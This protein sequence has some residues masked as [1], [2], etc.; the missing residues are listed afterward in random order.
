MTSL[1]SDKGIGNQLGRYDTPYTTADYMVKLALKYL[2]NPKKI[3]DPAMGGGVFIDAL[4]NNGIP[5]EK[6]TAFDIDSKVFEENP[7]KSPN[8]QV[9]DALLT[10]YGKYDLIIGNPPYK[11]RRQSEYIKKNKKTLSKLYEPIGLYNLYALF[12][13]KAINQLNENGIL[14]FIV[15]DSFCMNRYYRKLRNFILSSVKIKELILAPSSLFKTGK[16]DVRTVIIIFQKCSGPQNYSERFNSEM[17]LVDRLISEMQY[18]LPPKEQFIPQRK[19]HEMPD[20]KFFVGMPE[21]IFNLISKCKT[22]FGDISEGGTGISTGNDKQ[23]LKKAESI[24]DPNWVPFYKS[25]KR[26]PFFY[27][28]RFKINKNIDQSKAEGKD[29]LIRNRKFLFREGI[30]CSSIGR[31][32]S[33][34]Y[35]PPNCLFGVNAN[36]FFQT[37]EDLYFYLGILNSKVFEYIGRKFLNR[38]NIL[39]TSFIREFPIVEFSSKKKQDIAR[40]VHIIVEN[41]QKDPNYD[42]SALYNEIDE[43]IFELYDLNDEQIRAEITDFCENIYNRI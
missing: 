16:A 40:R 36:F 1:T 18:N 15:E 34:S 27:K 9:Q 35:M 13:F 38:S 6:I 19:Y 24:D 41:L 43:E 30:T 21:K 32:F 7:I 29:F 42:F 11:S 22:R 31:K 33:A 4:V 23:F 3:L 5:L 28:S 10:K 39:A 8:F 17:H 25:G 37:E 14:C 2:P 12:M 26:I 20:H